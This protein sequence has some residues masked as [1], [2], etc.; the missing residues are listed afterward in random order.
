VK[1]QPSTI[2]DRDGNDLSEQTLTDKLRAA[3]TPGAV[4]LVYDGGGDR[5][6]GMRAMR[7][8][9]EEKL[10]AQACCPAA[11]F[12]V[13]SSRGPRQRESD[14]ATDCAASR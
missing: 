12:P 6:N 5:E 2:L 7:T 13:G 8:V 3:F 11:P 14:S 9:V 4:L 1:D 10:G